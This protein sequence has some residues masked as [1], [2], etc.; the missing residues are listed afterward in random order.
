M[1]VLGI[2]AAAAF[3]Q[4]AIIT[5]TDGP[6]LLTGTPAA[7]SIYGRAG[8]DTING[9]GGDDEL[10]GGPGSDVLNGGDGSD[11]IA[12]TGSAGIVVSLDGVAND[13][14]AGEGDNVGNDVEDI[15]GADGP[16]KLG[17]SG[18]ANTIDGGA[19]EDRI[20]GG[21]GKDAIFGGDGDDVIEARDG[22]VDRIDCGPGD[23]VATIDRNDV[24]TRCEK[25]LRPPISDDVTL[26]RGHRLL[27]G[28]IDRGSTIVIACA[29]G[30]HPAL[31]PSKTLFKRTSVSGP[32][33]TF[34]LPRRVSGATLEI[35][36][37]IDRSTSC[38]RFRIGRQFASFKFLKGQ[39]CTTV[40]RPRGS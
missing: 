28:S 30:C 19:G 11:S 8:N 9:A 35:G 15:F 38:T 22:Q 21:A 32:L 31:S 16:D 26:L 20:T 4:D 39:S 6:D 10:D 1:I 5:G 14:A 12:Y 25:L 34:T 2:T 24:I 7:E 3:A 29:K 23:D 17:G 37:T 40:A 13:G 36:V 33:V 27:V 18:A